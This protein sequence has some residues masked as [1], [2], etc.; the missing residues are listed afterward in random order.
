MTSLSNGIKATDNKTGQEFFFYT[1]DQNSVENAM[2]LMGYGCRN[3]NLS[4]FKNREQPREERENRAIDALISL[5][6]K[7]PPERFEEVCEKIKKIEKEN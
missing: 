4:F 3:Y 6:M 1:E 2:D 7:V 5:C